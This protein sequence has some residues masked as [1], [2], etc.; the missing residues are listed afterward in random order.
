MSPLANGDTR[1][2]E[3]SVRAPPHLSPPLSLILHIMTHKHA[4]KLYDAVGELW[5]RSFGEH[6]HIGAPRGGPIATI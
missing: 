4:E 6:V 2:T 5:L 1:T 3:W